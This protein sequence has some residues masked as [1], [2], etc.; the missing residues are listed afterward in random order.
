[1]W[2]SV[3]TASRYAISMSVSRDCHRAISVA[4]SRDCHH[5]ISVWWSVGTASS[6]A[7][8]GGQ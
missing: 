3:G 2:R 8:S 5:V 4:V 6:C 7:V 1:M